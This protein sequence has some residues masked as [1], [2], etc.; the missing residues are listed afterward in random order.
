MRQCGMGGASAA[1]SGPREWL[2]QGQE[3]RQELGYRGYGRQ[4]GP[5]TSEG[6]AEKKP[7]Q[8][9]VLGRLLPNCVKGFKLKVKDLG[10]DWF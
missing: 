9:C 1:V 3:G 4:A 8:I 7:G 10:M 2:V 6:M 5:G